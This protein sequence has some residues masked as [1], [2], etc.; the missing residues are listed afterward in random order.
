MNWCHSAGDNN[1]HD[2]TGDINCHDN[3]GA[4]NRDDTDIAESE[5]QCKLRLLPIYN[6]RHVYCV[7]RLLTLARH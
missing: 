6:N 1:H 5:L 2:N 4:I 3:A 7:L